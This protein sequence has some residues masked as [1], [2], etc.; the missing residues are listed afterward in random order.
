MICHQN[1]F[2][3][4]A[5]AV[6]V[7]VTTPAQFTA[8]E[9]SIATSLTSGTLSTIYGWDVAVA[10]GTAGSA[11]LTWGQVPLTPAKNC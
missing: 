11:S 1:K 3:G 6:F 5:A 2:A 8:V 4:A 10:Y 7:P 9:S